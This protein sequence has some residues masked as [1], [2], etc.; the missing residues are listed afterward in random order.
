MGRVVV[1]GLCRIKY[2]NSKENLKTVMNLLRD[3][4]GNIQFEV[5]GVADIGLGIRRPPACR[6]L[7]GSLYPSKK[8]LK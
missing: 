5:S 6:W 2:I 7:R 1:M 4:S 3:K 8:R